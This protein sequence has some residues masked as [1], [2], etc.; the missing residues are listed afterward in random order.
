MAAGEMRCVYFKA[1]DGVLAGDLGRNFEKIEAVMQ[2]VQGATIHEDPRDCTTFL[3]AIPGEVDE[4]KVNGIAARLSS[5]T[6]KRNGQTL[7]EAWPSKV[8]QH[9]LQHGFTSKPRFS[10]D[11]P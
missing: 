5:L 9:T 11:F 3:V 7:L 8:S 4:S 2:D 10:Y 6:D 1:S